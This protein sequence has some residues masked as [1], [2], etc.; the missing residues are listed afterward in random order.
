MTSY[1]ESFVP[2]LELTDRDLDILMNVTI[3]G[4]EPSI[5]RIVSSLRDRNLRIIN[6]P[7]NYSV[8]ARY[9]R[10]VSFERFSNSL[11]SCSSMMT[12]DELTLFTEIQVVKDHLKAPGL[13][14]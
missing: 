6:T 5:N 10:N 12:Q 8:L 14:V 9:F 11:L 1:D 13:A 4:I 7:Q 2:L 3:E